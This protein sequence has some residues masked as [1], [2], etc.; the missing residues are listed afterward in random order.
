MQFGLVYAAV[1]AAF[2]VA[3]AIGFLRRAPSVTRTAVKALA[4]AFLAVVVLIED[5]P[6]LLAAALALCALGDA[7]LARS[8]PGDL[9]RGIA[10]FFAGHL[11]YILLFL[12]AG[13]GLGLN[14]I[15][16]GAQLAIIAASVFIARRLYSSL[17]AMRA[18]VLA[19]VGVIVAMTLLALGLP[20]VLWLASLGAVLFL[21]SDAILSFELFAWPKDAP[22]RRWS[23]RAVWGL[24]YAA[25]VLIVLS[26]LDRPQTPDG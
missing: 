15:A 20:P 18:P 13:G 2:S 16:I 7:L 5:G 12:V 9:E 25:Q 21:A 26:F 17:D 3:Y 10:A 4:V 8:E 11:F 23:D 19:Y 14:A 1:S 22:Q 24:Y 6:W